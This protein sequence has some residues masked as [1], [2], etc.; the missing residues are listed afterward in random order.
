MVPNGGKKTG[1]EIL[2]AMTQ[3]A[4]CPGLSELLM[5]DFFLTWIE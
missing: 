4:A 5:G 2:L 3:E 1:R